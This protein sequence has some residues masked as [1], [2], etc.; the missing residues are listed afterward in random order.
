M[1]AWALLGSMWEVLEASTEG[2]GEAA[3]IR[4]AYLLA[5]GQPEQAKL[6]SY[7][8]IYHN[9][10]TAPNFRMTVKINKE[11]GYNFG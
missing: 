7:K 5:V 4:V 8:V 9:N 10:M 6:L 3:A 11:I 2:I 1:S